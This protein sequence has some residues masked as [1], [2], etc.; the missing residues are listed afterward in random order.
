MEILDDLSVIYQSETQQN[1]K[2]EIFKSVICK[3]KCLMPDRA[4]V[5][6]S[7]GKKVVDFK[8]SLLG[9]EESVTQFLYCNAHFLLG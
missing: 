9:E 1:S 3:M 7:Y 2:D 6:K 5:M 4:S 8:S